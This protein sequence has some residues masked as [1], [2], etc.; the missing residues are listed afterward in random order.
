MMTNSIIEYI[1]KHLVT[2]DVIKDINGQFLP[3][4][5]IDGLQK[6]HLFVNLTWKRNE[7]DSC[8]E[9]LKKLRN[10]A[11][12][13]FELVSNH[14]QLKLCDSIVISFY[15]LSESGESLR[16]YRTRLNSALI[17]KTPECNYRILGA[18]EE[19]L[20]EKMESMF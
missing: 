11:Q 14:S 10:V 20:D 18:L 5:S 6:D 15:V 19:S 16:L 12:K 17:S 13:I 3:L 2:G 4:P 8:E 9:A 1:R 7:D